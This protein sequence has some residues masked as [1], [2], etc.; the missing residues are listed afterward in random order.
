MGRTLYEIGNDMAA[1]EALLIESGGDISDPK[2]AEAIGRW[3]QELEGD[4]TSKVDSYCMLIADIERRAQARWAEAD[5]LKQLAETDENAAEAL[6]ERLR[7]VFEL[8]NLKP[9]QTDRFRVALVKNG[10]KAPLDIRVGVDE[11]PDWAVK[12][13]LVLAPDKDA[14]RERLDKGEQLPFASLL[15]RG[16]RISIK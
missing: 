3:E 16:N 12:R 13:T 9:V 5:R 10:G 14:I 2:V 4:I 11:M 15:E 6:R 8:R 7:F 1:L